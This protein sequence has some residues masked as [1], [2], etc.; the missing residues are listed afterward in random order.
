MNSTQQ[1]GN[2][3]YWFNS[4]NEHLLQI[5]STEAMHAHGF[6][7]SEALALLQFLQ[8]NETEIQ[9]AAQ[10][11]AERDTRPQRKATLEERIDKL[12]G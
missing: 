5:F 6:L 11:Q 3:A 7:P 1:A 12:F 4:E 9:E 10:K 2:Y 8:S